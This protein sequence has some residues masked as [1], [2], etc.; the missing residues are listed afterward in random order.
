MDKATGTLLTAQIVTDGDAVGPTNSF[1]KNSSSLLLDVS[2][3]VQLILRQHNTRQRFTYFSYTM[4]LNF[5]VNLICFIL[6]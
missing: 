5:P 2:I 4:N 3:V 1:R 6:F